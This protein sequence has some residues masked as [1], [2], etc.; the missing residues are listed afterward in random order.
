ML[1][2]RERSA[3]RKIEEELAASDPAF[4]AALSQGVPPSRS[5]LWLITLVLADVTAVLM[6]VF[7]LLTGGSGLFLWGFAA[8]PALAW[9][10][11][12]LHQ[13][14]REPEAGEAG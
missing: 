9:V 3:L 10:H 4:V 6:V 13:G 12:G 8:L 14:K 11:H 2:Y 1:P 5:R 7:G